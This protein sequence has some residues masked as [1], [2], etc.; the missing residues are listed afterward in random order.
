MMYS[1]KKKLYYDV[2]DNTKLVVDKSE[3]HS[4][5]KDTKKDH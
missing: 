3:R 4:L 2:K 5:K 1:T